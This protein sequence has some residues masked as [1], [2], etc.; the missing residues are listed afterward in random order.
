MFTSSFPSLTFFVHYLPCPPCSRP[1]IKRSYSHATA[2]ERRVDVDAEHRPLEG[3]GPPISQTCN[4]LEV[5][6]SPPPPT[7]MLDCGHTDPWNLCFVFSDYIFL[8]WFGLVWLESYAC[9]TF[10]CWF[11]VSSYRCLSCGSK[12]LVHN[13]ITRSMCVVV[14]SYASV[15]FSFLL[16]VLGS[17]DGACLSNFRDIDLLFSV[18]CL[19]LFPSR[20]RTCCHSSPWPET[21]FSS[22]VYDLQLH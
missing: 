3:S 10:L 5:R 8:V 2:T 22:I 7:Y 14:V 9:V 15:Y 6:S 4:S 1:P 19:H 12:T 13:S 21:A 11:S 16:S 17:V 18:L 20:T